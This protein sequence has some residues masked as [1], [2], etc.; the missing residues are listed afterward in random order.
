MLKNYFTVAFRHLLRRKLFSLINVS[1]LALGITFSLI[2]GVYV[3]NQ[4]NI[5]RSLKNVSNQSLIKSKWKEKDMSLDIT[6]F[7]PLAKS[8][9]EEYPSLVANYYRYDPVT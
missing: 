5:N 1:C 4:Y 3:L 8:L 2:I 7:G 9:R 6:T